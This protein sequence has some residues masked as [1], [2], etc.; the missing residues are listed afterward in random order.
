MI[1]PFDVFILILCALVAFLVVAVVVLVIV[2][3]TKNRR[4]I[5]NTNL[6]VGGNSD[7]IKNSKMIDYTMSTFHV[8]SE[9]QAIIINDNLGQELELTRPDMKALANKKFKEITN[10]G[11]SIGS[12]TAQGAIPFLA[13]AQ[14]ISEISKVAPNGLFTATAPISELMKFSDGTVGSAV[15]G[16]GGIVGQS[17]FKEVGLSAIS[18]INPATVIGAGMQAMAAISGQYYMHQISNQ[19]LSIDKKL[20]KLVN[21]HH[22]EK[23]AILLTIKD[24]LKD[25]TEKSNV[26]A[27]DIIGIHNLY[28]DSGKVFNEY[29]LRLQRMDIRDVINV[30]A[31]WVDKPKEIRALS[32]SIDRHEIDLSLQICFYANF[33]YYQC[34]LAEVATRM[35]MIKNEGQK[36]IIKEQLEKIRSSYKESFFINAGKKIDEFYLPIIDK[37]TE[38]AESGRVTA[39][40]DMYWYDDTPSEHMKIKA[41]EINLKDSLQENELKSLIGNVLQ[42]FENPIEILY[43]PSDNLKEQKMFVCE[44]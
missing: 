22:D 40:K 26:D 19:L 20:D 30:K 41:R 7:L 42:L 37:S 28:T 15:M 24:R 14:T 32:D 23:T 8:L 16:N 36:E 12:H 5:L 3:V 29:Y 27:A 4:K 25:I 35:K 31:R 38:I 34:K 6:E 13:Q 39:E 1:I 18:Q 21:F 44:D 43:L 11:L 33:L 17:G 2:L 9:I 10:N